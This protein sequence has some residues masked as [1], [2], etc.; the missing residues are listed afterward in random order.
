LTNIRFSVQNV[1][2]LSAILG[3]CLPSASWLTSARSPNP[4]PFKFTYPFTATLKG[5][6]PSTPIFIPS[7]ILVTG[8][9]WT[10]ATIDGPSLNGTIQG[11][12]DHPSIYGKLQLPSVDVYGMSSDVKLFYLHGAGIGS[13]TAKVARLVSTDLDEKRKA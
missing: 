8:R 4:L 6:N 11:G 12:F 7:G 9:A 3:G 10:T 2:V 5:D 1:L 13:R